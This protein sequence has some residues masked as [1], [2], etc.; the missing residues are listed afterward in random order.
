MFK[1][2]KHTS[3]LNTWSIKINSI[4]FY[5]FSD[6]LIEIKINIIVKETKLNLLL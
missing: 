5:Q 6:L 2:P 3:F 4:P 1:T